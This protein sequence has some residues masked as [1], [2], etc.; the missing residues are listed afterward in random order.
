MYSNKHEATTATTKFENSLSFSIKRERTK[1]KKI[2]NLMNLIIQNNYPYFHRLSL[3][4]RRKLGAKLTVE[5]KQLGKVEEKYAKMQCLDKW[6]SWKVKMK[7]EIETQRHLPA[8]RKT[9]RE[10]GKTKHGIGTSQKW[11]NETTTIASVWMKF[12]HSK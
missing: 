5:P 6:E 10:K 4:E 9:K 2:L 3:H 8:A 12:Y 7:T 11:D 1:T